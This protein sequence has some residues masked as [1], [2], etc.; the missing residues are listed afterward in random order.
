MAVCG[1]RLSKCSFLRAFDARHLCSSSA[2]RTAKQ[3]KEANEPLYED[4]FSRLIPHSEHRERQRRL[5]SLVEKRFGHNKPNL[6]LIPSAQQSFQADTKI[7][8]IYYKQCADFIYFTG[9]NTKDA[10]NCILAI[11]AGNGE[12]RSLLFAPSVDEYQ[13]F[14]EGPGL[15]A[16]SELSFCDE[17]VDLKKFDDFLLSNAKRQVFVSKNGLYT[18]KNGFGGK[19]ENGRIFQENGEQLTLHHHLSSF[20][21]ELRLIKSSNELKAMRRCCRI[22]ANAL[23]ETMLWTQNRH[24]LN[25]E[26]FNISLINENQIAAKFD[27]ECRVNG[28][29]KVSYPSVCASGDRSTVIHYGNNN[30]FADPSEWILMDAGCEDIEGYVSD[31]TRSWQLDGRKDQSRLEFALYQALC[32]VHKEIIVSIEES[33]STLDSLFEIMCHFLAKVLIEFGICG[34]FTSEVEAFRMAYRY[35]PH[36][37][38]HYIGL[39]VHDTP[40]ISRNILLKPGMCF[41]V[42][43]GLYFRKNDDV[44][45]E[46]R[47]IGLRVE[48][49]ICINENGKV[50]N[51]TESA[52]YL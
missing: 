4:A 48:D 26:Q 3:N 39:D 5:V 32:E 22:G 43:P 44:R 21:D 40:T 16:E 42:E 19:C 15:T 28:A 1:R 47:G 17:V 30:R 37:V 18:R 33:N 23:R 8:S 52:P 31:I 29:K 41:T 38:S 25:S 13:S 51:L 27:Y 7:P 12:T 24:E 50:E 35:C 34:K 46:F 2:V 20:I 45:P 11:L 6:L 49:D 14:W 36:H 10:V 9:L